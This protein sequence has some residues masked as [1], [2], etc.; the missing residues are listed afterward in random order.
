MALP[1]SW[2]PRSSSG[3]RSIRFYQTGTLTVVFTGNAFVFA[4]QTTAN[5]YLPT[6]YVPPGGE[7]VNAAVGTTAI[8]GSPMGGGRDA[9]DS[10]PTAP[11]YPMIW[12]HSIRIVNT[13]GGVLEFSFD[14]TN[15]HG[16]LANN[17]DVTYRNRY[18][19]GIA[20][21]GAGGGAF[22]IEAW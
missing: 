3:I 18:E 16:S 21:R 6:P 2:P 22:Q 7:R 19:A 10:S 14:G 13:S 17:A 8:P 11:P 15:V 20:V 1:A 9:H 12:A 4:D 5:P